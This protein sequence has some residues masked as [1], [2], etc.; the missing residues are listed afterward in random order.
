[1]TIC[2][3][4]HMNM[5]VSTD[6]V[7]DLDFI[8]NTYFSWHWNTDLAG[9]LARVLD[10]LLVTL[11]IFLSMDLQGVSQ[12]AVSLQIDL[13]ITNLLTANLTRE[14]VVRDIARFASLSQ[15]WNTAYFL[16]KQILQILLYTVLFEHFPC[17]MQEHLKIVHQKF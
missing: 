4:L 2:I 7:G 5:R 13:H 1:M 6:L 12:K 10:W 8:W 14:D 15:T 11:S 17:K 9:D 16:H 3:L